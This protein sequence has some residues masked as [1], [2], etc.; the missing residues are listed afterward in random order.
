MRFLS[1]IL[2]AAM[3]NVVA[4]ASSHASEGKLDFDEYGVSYLIEEKRV[5]EIFYV[6]LEAFSYLNEVELKYRGRAARSILAISVEGIFEDG[7]YN[8]EKLSRFSEEIRS[9]LELFEVGE[10]QCLISG[11]KTREQSPDGTVIENWKTVAVFNNKKNTI[12][13][14][15]KCLYMGVLISFGSDPTNI[16]DISMMSSR[17]LAKK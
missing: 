9:I 12:D 8:E 17:K 7:G 4:L 2:T 14:Q 10:K 16:E 3:M 13:E 6:T 11:F 1:I 5:E 15:I